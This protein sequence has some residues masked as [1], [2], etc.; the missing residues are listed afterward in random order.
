[1]PY[2]MPRALVLRRKI[3]CLHCIAELVEKGWLALKEK[4]TYFYPNTDELCVSIPDVEHMIRHHHIRYNFP[5]LEG[6][7]PHQFILDNM[8]CHRCKTELKDFCTDY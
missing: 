1:M 3:F 6:Q 7:Q 8:K 4:E 2:G 5:V